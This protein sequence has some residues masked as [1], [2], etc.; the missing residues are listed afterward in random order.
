[1]SFCLC[2]SM[3]R[4]KI[5]VPSKYFACTYLFKETKHSNADI[6]IPLLENQCF[7]PLCQCITPL[8]LV[9]C[10]TFLCR[11]SVFCKT[12]A[13][14]RLCDNARPFSAALWKKDGRASVYSSFNGRNVLGCCHLLCLR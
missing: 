3:V 12:Y 9:S 14:Q 1:M 7:T 10:A 2:N 5:R 4:C 8:Q 11:W 6:F 13:I